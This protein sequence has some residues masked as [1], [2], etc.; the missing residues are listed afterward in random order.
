[1]GFVPVYIDMNVKTSH[2]SGAD[3]L[4]KIVEMARKLELKAIVVA[5][6]FDSKKELKTLRSEAEKITSDVKVYVG[7]E[8]KAETPKELK[9][10]V[11]RFRKHADV[12]LVSGGNVEINRAA[13]ENPFV[14]VLCHPEAGRKD[15]GMDHVMA[16]Q[17]S[18]YNVAIELNF[19]EFLHAS[20]KQRSHIL[21]HM[22]RNVMLAEK[23]GVNV[24]VTSGA[25]SI[26]EMR[27]GRELAALAYVVGMTRE[28][29][30]R[31]TSSIP[32][33]IIARALERKR[34]DFVMPGVRVVR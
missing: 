21:A 7:V 30:V 19:R 4:E 25:G 24:V 17:A 20:K 26:W 27:A 28:H 16:K 29:A 33:S 11:E 2:S 12:I 23:Y 22:C 5:D 8:I 1:V 14:D 15:S 10:K 13:C 9:S 31:T 34:P 18:I 32:E 3:S 6:T